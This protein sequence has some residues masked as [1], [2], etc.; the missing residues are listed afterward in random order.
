MT[1][2]QKLKQ[3]VHGLLVY[4]F[5]VLLAAILA[6]LFTDENISLFG[7]SVLILGGVWVFIIGYTFKGE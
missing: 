2:K 5:L 7:K 1:F 4:S 6:S 3:G